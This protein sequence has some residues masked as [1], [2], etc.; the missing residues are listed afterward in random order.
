MDNGT[1][2]F[3]QMMRRLK[4]VFC[5]YIFGKEIYLKD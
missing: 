2:Y 4:L 5:N 3:I 1:L